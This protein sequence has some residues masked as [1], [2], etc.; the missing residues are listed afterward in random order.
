[1]EMRIGRPAFPRHRIGSWCS[2]GSGRRRRRLAR[3]ADPGR[4]VYD[5]CRILRFASDGRRT[6]EFSRTCPAR[7]GGASCSGSWGAPREL[8]I[9]GAKRRLD[10]NIEAFRNRMREI[11]LSLIA[12]AA[13]RVRVA[14]ALG[15]IKRGQNLPVV[16]Y[17]QERI[18]LERAGRAAERHGLDPHVAQDLVA[19]LIR[20][21]VTVQEEDRLRLSATGAGKTA[22]VVGGAGRMGRWFVEFLSAQGYAAGQNSRPKRQ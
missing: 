6:R 4:A 11:D 13:E 10:E 17:A 16:D 19:R 21:S 14:R 9:F 12:L 20:A 7:P 5:D 15:E 18:V 1:M 8:E 2:R 3:K 22:V